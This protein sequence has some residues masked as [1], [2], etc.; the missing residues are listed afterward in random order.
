M[1]SYPIDLTDDDNGTVLATSPDFPELTTFGEDRD[2]ALLHAVDAL[3]EAI[4][5]R[6]AHRE[7]VPVPSAGRY[8][9][10]L[11]TQTALKVLLYR[12]M[13]ERGVRK[14]ELARR[15]HW[16]G[17]QVDRLLDLR[18]ASRLKQ[19]DDAFHALGLTLAITTTEEE[20]RRSV[21]R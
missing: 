14:A 15:L 19:L 11:P 4:A 9:A 3:E 7:D 20:P 18:H 12:A 16:K 5:A 13:R 17:P 6:I 10:A 21:R 8:R 1:L 2:D